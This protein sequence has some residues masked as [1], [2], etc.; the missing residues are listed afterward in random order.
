MEKRISIFHG[1]YYFKTKYKDLYILC[2]NFFSK[3]LT[4]N[5]AEKKVIINTVKKILLSF[6]YYLLSNKNKYLEFIEIFFNEKLNLLGTECR[7]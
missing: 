2:R 6:I 1:S 4:N 7:N 3:S 5:I